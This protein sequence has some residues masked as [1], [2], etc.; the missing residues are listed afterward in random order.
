M[1]SH[2]W[3]LI[4]NLIVFVLGFASLVYAASVNAQMRARTAAGN[5]V[6]LLVDSSGNLQ[7]VLN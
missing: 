4:F 1:K 6:D 5:W 2:K 7:V 3:C